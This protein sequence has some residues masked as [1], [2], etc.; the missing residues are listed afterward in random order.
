MT[1]TG[2]S[3]QPDRFT[4]TLSH[5]VTGFIAESN[6]V[7]NGIKIKVEIKK[8][9]SPDSISPDIVALYCFFSDKFNIFMCHNN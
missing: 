4:I 3:T 1:G 6:S 9:C 5:S 2:L 8:I 7:I